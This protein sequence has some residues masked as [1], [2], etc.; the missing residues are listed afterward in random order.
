MHQN[1]RVPGH[2]SE[3]VNNYWIIPGDTN[4]NVGFSLTLEEQFVT[5]E[6]VIQVMLQFDALSPGNRPAQPHSSMGG[7]LAGQL[8]TLGVCCFIERYLISSCCGKKEHTFS[9]FKP[10]VSPTVVKEFE[11]N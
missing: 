5:M 4:L 11:Q 1:Q 8:E 10:S 6:S 3:F 7:H 9:I 2:I